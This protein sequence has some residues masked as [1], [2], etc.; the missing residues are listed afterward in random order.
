MEKD[1]IEKNS[2]TNLK[3]SYDDDGGHEKCKKEETIWSLE[4]THKVI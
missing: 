3:D 2:N 4:L 1:K